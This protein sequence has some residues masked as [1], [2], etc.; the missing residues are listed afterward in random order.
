[1]RRTLVSLAEWTM[2][3]R[4]HR[5]QSLTVSMSQLDGT[6]WGFITVEG[7][8]RLEKG[9]KEGGREGGRDKSTVSIIPVAPLGPKTSFNTVQSF[10]HHQTVVNVG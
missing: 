10:T 6:R 8:W 2:F 1:M 9:E 3:I 7:R 4:A 5:L